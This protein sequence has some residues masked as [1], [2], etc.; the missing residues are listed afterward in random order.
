MFKFLHVNFVFFYRFR[1][2]NWSVFLF[3]SQ[4]QTTVFM[5]VC[6][7]RTNMYIVQCELWTGKL[8]SI[9]DRGYAVCSY[10]RFIIRSFNKY[11]PTINAWLSFHICL[12][13]FV[14]RDVYSTASSYLQ[15]II[16]LCVIGSF[17]IYPKIEIEQLFTTVTFPWPGFVGNKIIFL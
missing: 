4:P 17:Q 15:S 10:Q 12:L 14:Y 1:L 8:H 7:L 2:W 5:C 16:R 11:T 6:A 3:S 9:H 13:S